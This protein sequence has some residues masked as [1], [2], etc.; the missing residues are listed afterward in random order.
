MKTLQEIHAESKRYDQSEPLQDAFVAG[1]QFAL[2]GK[3]YKPSELFAKD[4]QVAEDN[5][6]DEWWNLYDKKRGKKKALAKWR[7]LS[8]KE[9]EA[10]LLA[11]PAYVASTPDVQ[12]RLDPLTY[13]NG[14]RWND[15]IIQIPSHEQQHTINLARKA[16]RILGAD[17]QG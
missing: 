15:E 14:E 4:S 10:C 1:A 2:T 13:L 7:K 5:S 17:R 6:F 3:Y 9:Q 8:K 16:A 12:Y 11:T